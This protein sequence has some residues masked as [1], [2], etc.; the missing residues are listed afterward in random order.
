MSASGNRRDFLHRVACCGA[1]VGLH[2]VL[3]AAEKELPKVADHTLTTFSGKP[4]ARG[5]Q[6]GEKF[7]GDIHAFLDREIYRAC[8]GHATREA[9]LRY[10]G[11]CTEAVKEYSR[12]VLDEMEGMAEGAGLK[13][14]ELVLLTLHE[15]TAGHK[16]GAL[17]PVTHC[18][19]LAAGPPDTKDGH[20]YVGQNWDWMDSVYGL[21]R[22]LLWKRLE[23][24]SVLAHSYPGL[25]VGAGVNAAGGGPC[26]TWGDGLGLQ[27]P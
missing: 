20:G 6:Y 21:S 9:L 8:A 25:W 10:A 7:K 19:A 27:G 15:E 17:P 4:R 5:R 3:P 2:G 24:P 22:M 23:G 14:E 12:A 1:A 13:L 11:Q 26:W 18:T 16:G